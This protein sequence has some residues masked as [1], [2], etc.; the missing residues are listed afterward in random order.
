MS[1]TTSVSN[2]QKQIEDRF[3]FISNIVSIVSSLSKKAHQNKVHAI[4]DLLQCI[5][6]SAYSFKKILQNVDIWL[7]KST[8]QRWNGL[9]N[10]ELFEKKI[11][12]ALRQKLVEW[13]AK[14]SNVPEYPIARDTLLI[15]DAELG[16]KQR[17]TKLIL[18]CSM[19]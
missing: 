9:S 13:I 2:K 18:E 6:S 12:K 1:H 15:T 16:V 8:I 4:M 14:N 17:V 11:N 5:M 19:Q 10:H 3:F 7:L